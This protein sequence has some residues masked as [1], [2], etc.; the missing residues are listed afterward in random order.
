MTD[1]SIMYVFTLKLAHIIF[2]VNLFYA[3]PY[4]FF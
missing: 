4:I 1:L 3:F 2:D